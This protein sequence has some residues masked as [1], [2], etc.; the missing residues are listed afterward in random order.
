MSVLDLDEL[1]LKLK[2][3]DIEIRKCIIYFLLKNQ[4][5]NNDNIL[6]ELIYKT[7]FKESVVESCI[8]WTIGN[9]KIL[10]NVKKSECDNLLIFNIENI[11]N[12]SVKNEEDLMIYEFINYNY[13]NKVN[14]SC[15]GVIKNK[16]SSNTGNIC[17]YK[18]IY[19]LS[20][21]KWVCGYHSRINN[22]IVN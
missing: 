8:N 10:L 2:V 17:P 7:K 3:Y 21:G 12:N 9:I 16:H 15:V 13:K 1:I 11:I 6:I 19:K 4:Y 22:A 18:G 5:P 20:T 14:N